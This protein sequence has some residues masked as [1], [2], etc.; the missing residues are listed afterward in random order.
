VYVG[1]L[2]YSTS[3][4]NLK[5][6]F[7]TVGDVKRADLLVGR[8]GRPNGGGIVEFS[9]PEYAQAAIRD[10]T[11]VEL[12]GRRIFVREDRE[13]KAPI[14]KA[15]AT[16]GPRMES[17]GRGNYVAG[18][19]ANGRAA[20]GSRTDYAPTRDVGPVRDVRESRGGYERYSRGYERGGYDRAAL[21]RGAYDRAGYDRLYD[22]GYDRYAAPEA[23]PMDPVAYA[24]WYREWQR[25]NLLASSSMVSSY[26]S[27]AT[28][29]LTPEYGHARVARAEEPYRKPRSAAPAGGREPAAPGTRVFFGNLPFTTSWQ[30]LKDVLR[31]RGFNNV[32]VAM[33]QTPEGRPRGHGIVTFEQPADA[34]RAVAELHNFTFEGR[35]MDVHLDRFD[36]QA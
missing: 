8:D 9:M 23:E 26:R 33:N 10:L 31:E 36:G 17:G 20:A 13:D 22:R 11:D 12:D 3:W 19:Y 27:R 4:Q 18:Q 15:A 6:L 7:K 5:D 14:E 34:D 1:N 32:H 24:A 29:E 28:R 21:D 2:S 25:D 16:G 35:S 30:A